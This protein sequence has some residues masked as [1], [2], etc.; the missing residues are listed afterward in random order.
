MTSTTRTNKLST[1]RQAQGWQRL[2]CWLE[3]QAAKAL[4]DYCEKTKKKP[5]QAIAA[6][7]GAS[8]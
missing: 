8:S 5:A 1:T 2:N 3:P 7:L 6:L 4:A